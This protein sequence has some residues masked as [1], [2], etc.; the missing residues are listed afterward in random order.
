MPYTSATSPAARVSV[1]LGILGPE[2]EGPFRDGLSTRPAS[3]YRAVHEVSTFCFGVE[4]T[5]V[6]GARAVVRSRDGGSS[7]MSLLGLRR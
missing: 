1:E 3:V 2:V 5:R 6:M 7:M 4:C